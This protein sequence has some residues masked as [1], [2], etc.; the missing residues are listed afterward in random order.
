MSE[1]DRM[2]QRLYLMQLSTTDLPLATGQVLAMSTG[3]YLV[4]T[5]DGQNILID[6]G[7]PADY[8]RPAGTPASKNQKNVLEHLA[9]LHISPEDI[10][11][12]I[13]THFDVDHA[14]YHDA[15][16]RAIHIVQRAH[17]ELARSGHQR[18]QGARAHWDH[19]ALHYQMV[20]GDTELL[21]GLTLIETS[22]HVSG[23]QSVLL[24]LPQ[25][26]NV[27]LAIDA[28]PLQ[29][30]FTPDRKASP[31]DDD[32]V[33]LRDSTR[34]LMYIA[35]REH[36]NLLVF[37]HDGTQWQTLKKAPEFYT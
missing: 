35:E 26:G 4:Q 16:K 12:V 30:L 3:C 31:I 21:P 10:S 27:L 19:P 9:D 25:T 14:G 18:L 7:L 15:F 1:T 22:G 17:Y 28:V 20:E 29:R 23:H 8:S 11:M 13:S 36:V 34:K 2:P 33:Q 24:H 32:E 37:G 5:G 6:S